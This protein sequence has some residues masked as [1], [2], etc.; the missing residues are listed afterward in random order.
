MYEANNSQY[1]LSK[2]CGERTA[3][4]IFP[5]ISESTFLINPAHLCPSIP[6]RH[7]RPP[8]RQ[9]NR[10]P[11]IPPKLPKLHQKPHVPKAQRLVLHRR[12]RPRSNLRSSNPKIRLRLPSLQ[13][14]K[15]I[16]HSPRTHQRIPRESMPEC[17][18]HVGISEG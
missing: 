11:R 4:S 17:E 7:L 16:H 6:L 14:N 2:L 18:N 10:T 1:A 3:V 13:C 5:F 15:F 9:R 12:P 8:Y